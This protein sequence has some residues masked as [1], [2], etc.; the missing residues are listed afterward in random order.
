MESISS[1]AEHNASTQSRP[2]P[3]SHDPIKEGKEATIDTPIDKY[4]QI[5][6]EYCTRCKK[7]MWMELF[8]PVSE[9]SKSNG[10]PV[11]D[12][13][14][15]PKDK[16]ED[17]QC[18]L[19]HLFA[20]I[21]P[22]QKATRANNRHLRAFTGLQI[23]PLT[24]IARLS[25][26]KT[27]VVLKVVE[28]DPG[29]DFPLSRYTYMDGNLILS[30]P[31]P[32]PSPGSSPD[33]SPEPFLGLSPGPSQD[34]SSFDRGSLDGP[35]PFGECRL[36]PEHVDFEKVGTWLRTGQTSHSFCQQ[37]QIM[38]V[39]SPGPSPGPS[40]EP[41]PRPSSGPSSGPPP[42][43]SQDESSFN[44]RSLAGPFT[45]RGSRVNPEHVDFK[46]VG[47][48]LETCQRSHLSCRRKL[49]SRPA[50]LRGIDCVNRE[51]VRL[52]SD[53]YVT[54]SYVWGQ[55]APLDLKDPP[56]LIL[57]A[58]IVTRQMNCRYLWV[59]QCCIEQGNTDEKL[60][61]IRNMDKIY[62]G[63]LCTIVSVSAED[64]NSPFSGISVLRKIQPSALVEGKTLVSSLSSLSALNVRSKWASRGWTYQE[65]LL[66]RRC[67]FF[68]S[69]QA[70]FVFCT[71]DCCESIVRPPISPE[72]EH[73]PSL[74]NGLL[75]IRMFDQDD[76]DAREVRDNR[77][78]YQT[79][80]QIRAYTQRQ[81]TYN[82]DILNAFRGLLN[83]SNFHSFWGIYL[84]DY[85]HRMDG[86]ELAGI[87]FAYGLFWEA[88]LHD[89]LAR[90]KGFP[91]WSWAGWIFPPTFFPSWPRLQS[92]YIRWE[93]E[94][95]HDTV[96][97]VQNER[98]T[99]INMHEAAQGANGRCLP[100][101]SQNIEISGLVGEVCLQARDR[102]IPGQSR[103]VVCY[104]HP[105]SQHPGVV[106][107]Q[108]RATSAWLCELPSAT[109][110][111]NRSP[112]SKEL[113]TRSFLV[114]AVK[115]HI[116][117]D[118]EDHVSMLLIAWVGETAERLGSL[119]LPRSVFE[120]LPQERRVVIIG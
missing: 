87:G 78:T 77:T 26:A 114:Y 17:I 98:G 89:G 7:V 23:L 39:P 53:D 21:Q 46:K 6:S 45:L 51:V 92:D 84:Y 54:L 22:T 73:H 99:Y 38:S 56:P 61:Q 36:N 14:I 18:P 117:E 9:V 57:D 19:C 2:K 102:A 30:V 104:C 82:D 40:P 97:K 75:P 31:S 120:V 83:R 29:Q 24:D 27:N 74:V 69:E 34:E 11:M 5:G 1:C 58:M 79:H 116:D 71:M 81:L 55:S 48:W 59:D 93:D 43:P 25:N 28:G 72:H 62:E 119:Y 112:E 76:V 67:I 32:E 49:I 12:L 20:R 100:E 86:S 94:D 41:S 109:E 101:I 8:P 110:G 63:A 88:K 37:K 60:D 118:A 52:G 108:V 106:D 115:L 66:S 68:T 95:R 44:R 113:S 85:D 65:A 105:S 16:F 35:L 13:G 10:V 33:P 91:S 50:M 42:E 96:F 4:R 80:D 107:S 103:F 70:Y 15:L 3:N 64:R 90:R 47:S 111:N